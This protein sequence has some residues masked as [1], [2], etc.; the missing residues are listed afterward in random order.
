MGDSEVNELYKMQSGAAQVTSHIPVELTAYTPLNVTAQVP[1]DITT[2]IPGLQP[3]QLNGVA[4]S[5]HPAV[6]PQQFSHNTDILTDRHALQQVY[7]VSAQHDMLAF[8]LTSTPASQTT[9]LQKSACQP[10][11]DAVVKVEPSECGTELINPEQC[12][13]SAQNTLADHTDSAI[14][15]TDSDVLLLWQTIGEWTRLMSDAAIARFLLSL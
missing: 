3:Q 15:V 13:S 2:D 6:D 9:V 8:Q 4:T 11:E 14:I 10:S 1:V 7:S 12:T 5:L